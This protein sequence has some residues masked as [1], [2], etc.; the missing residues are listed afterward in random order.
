MI[1]FDA[2]PYGRIN[3]KV[4][5]MTPHYSHYYHEGKVPGDWNNPTPIPFLT[6][7]QHQKFI[8]YLAPRTEKDIED[9][10]RVLIW[11]E[12]ALTIIG[13]GAKT[14]IGYGRFKTAEDDERA[15]HEMIKQK[16]E[17]M[18][19]KQKV[20][21]MTPIRRE[22]ESDGYSEDEEKFMRIL[23][24]KWLERLEDEDEGEIIKKEIAK[25]LADWYKKCRPKQWKKPTG[26]N[27]MKV[28]KIKS[29]IEMISS[30]SISF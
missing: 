20:A 26:K 14:A 18:V 21:E 10:N 6:V 22:M 3:L 15:F 17:E 24:V 7:D 5:V 12:E 29:F 2:L 27:I 4:D 30:C 23:T 11:F 16:V 9:F 8:F 19:R 25:H 28:K 1:F 13:T